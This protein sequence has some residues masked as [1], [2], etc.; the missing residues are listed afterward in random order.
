MN[1]LTPLFEV[2]S[3]IL[4]TTDIDLSFESNPRRIFWFVGNINELPEDE[5]GMVIF[6]HGSLFE[7]IYPDDLDEDQLDRWVSELQAILDDYNTPL[8]KDGLP[9]DD[10]DFDRWQN[11]EEDS[12]DEIARRENYLIDSQEDRQ[13]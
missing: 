2:V 12:R 7:Y 1:V 6:E 13:I 11:N 4:T 8:D 3:E 10:D 5:K 9:I